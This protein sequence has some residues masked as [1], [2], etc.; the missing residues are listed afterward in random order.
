M[1][2][3]TQRPA[4]ICSR[5][6]ESRRPRTQG[7]APASGGAGLRAEW[8][9]PA[10]VCRQK[11]SRVK[12][13]LAASLWPCDGSERRRHCAAGNLET[14]LPHFRPFQMQCSGADDVSV[15]KTQNS[16]CF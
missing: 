13:T 16:S 14:E 4:V 9:A 6:P 7:W 1:H 8:E 5:R 12:E 3:A 10:N 2:H 11:P 15:T